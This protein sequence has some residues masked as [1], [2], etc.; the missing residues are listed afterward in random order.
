MRATSHGT[1]R[2]ESTTNHEHTD[3]GA[4]H[5]YG[6]CLADHVHCDCGRPAPLR[7]GYCGS[8]VGR[9]AACGYSWTVEHD[10]V[11]CWQR[12]TETDAFRADCL[13]HVVLP[14]VAARVV[15]DR[16]TLGSGLSPALFDRA[17]AGWEHFVDTFEESSD[18]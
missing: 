10:P 8:V 9:C 7:L 13:R 11:D 16:H 4:P 18:G 2:A 12:T 3:A 17:L 6:T 5:S 15:L 1:A 14:L